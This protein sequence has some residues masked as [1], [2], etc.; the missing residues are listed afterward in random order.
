MTI[1]DRESISDMVS[2]LLPEKAPIVI[3]HCAMGIVQTGVHLEES[4][5]GIS[6][7]LILTCA[8]SGGDGAPLDGLQNFTISLFAARVLNPGVYVVMHNWAYRMKGSSPGGAIKDLPV[9]SIP[10][11][12]ITA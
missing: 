8:N 9:A 3:T 10:D 7:P 6:V 12:E 4:L 1:R 2:V 11:G 5:A